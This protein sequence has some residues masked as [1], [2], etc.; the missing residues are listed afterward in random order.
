AH[1]VLRRRDFF[2][3]RPIHG[4]DVKDVNWFNIAGEEMSDAE[5]TEGFAKSLTVFLNG[6]GIPYMGPRGEQV[7]DQS[8]MLL[9]N[10]HYEPLAFTLPGPDFGEAWEVVV[11]TVDWDVPEPRP[12]VA[13]KSTIELA[14]RT[15]RL[16]VEVPPA[17]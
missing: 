9:F 2:H 10:A 13:A 6:D 8:L 7:V 5:W 3:G 17:T 15:A 14:A 16:L 1:P 11:D 12:V 4:R